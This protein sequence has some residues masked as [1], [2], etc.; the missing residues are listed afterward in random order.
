MN[1]EEPRYCQHFNCRLDTAADLAFMAVRLLRPDLMNMAGE[2]HMSTVR[3]R[4]Q[5]RKGPV[6]AP[7]PQAKYP[8]ET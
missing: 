1:S 2:V 7:F 4:L 5:P 8:E 3:C 6:H